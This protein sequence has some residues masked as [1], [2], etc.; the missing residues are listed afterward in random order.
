MPYNFIAA[1]LIKQVLEGTIQYSVGKT[2]LACLISTHLIQ[3]Y[4]C[5]HH[6]DGSVLEK[7][8]SNLNVFKPNEYFSVHTLPNSLLHLTV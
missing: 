3:S 5:P 2:S 7:V 8:T 4:V 6:S 1:V